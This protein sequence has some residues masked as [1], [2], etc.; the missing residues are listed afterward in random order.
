MKRRMIGIAT[1]VALAGLG[2]LAI[3]GYI[4]SAEDRALAG[5]R[6]VDV[7]VV[8]DA[9]DA[10]TPVSELADSVATEEVPAKLKPEGAVSSLDGLD[11]LVTSVALLPGEELVTTRLVDPGDLDVAAQTGVP[12]GMQQVTISLEPQRAVGGKIGPGTTVAV[13]ASFDPFQDSENAGSTPDATHTILHKVLVTNVQVEQLPSEE[14]TDGGP[15]L[16]PTGNLLV[17]LALDAPS[18]E[19][20]VFAAEHGSIWL[21]REPG[22]APTEGTQVWT[23]SVIYS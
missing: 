16:A 4:G 3:V 7:L 5:E 20:V 2:T 1:A 17:T 14:E 23:R 15:S 9:V 21:S 18:V 22:D 11:G 10:G 13:T 6:M 12:D 8:A 19:R